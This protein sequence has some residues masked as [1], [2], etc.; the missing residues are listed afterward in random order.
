MRIG[1]ITPLHGSPGTTPAAPT[2]NSIAELA[3][4]A[5]DSGFTSFVFEDALLYRGPRTAG[6]W[7]SVAIAGALGSATNRIRFG[8]SVINSPYRSPA[9]V[10]KIAETLDEISGGRYIFAIGAGNTDDSDYEAFG[11]QN[12]HRYS[13]FAEAIEIIH[14]LLKTGAVDFEGEFYSARESEL[15]L[16]GPRPNGPPI[17]IA[18]AGP[19]M[20]RLVAR[21]ADAWNWWT[22]DYV[23]AR[24]DLA[25]LIARLDQACSEAGRDPSTLGR[26][27]DLYTVD[28]L[29]VTNGEPAGSGGRMLSGTPA[30][31]AEVILGF[32]EL[33]FDEV[34]CD[35]YPR[36]AHAVAA[37]GDVISHV[38]NS[39]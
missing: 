4:V 10:A 18:A 12:D 39:T 27:L 2:W 5:E 25:S 9:L 24:S 14:G 31:M 32:G 16:R 15:V 23:S 29:R 38:R 22:S 30:D 7:E 21:Y 33:G 35:V 20:L 19:K 3:L 17:T 36:T 8:H 13:R 37:M 34:R 6:S 11:A 1:L 26:S 28:P